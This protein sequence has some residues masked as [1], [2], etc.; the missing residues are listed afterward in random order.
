MTCPICSQLA[1]VESA[2]QKY[3]WEEGNTHLPSESLGLVLVKDLRPFSSRKL[4]LKQCPVCG[5]W[6]L[7]QTDYEYLVNGSEDEE[8]LYR[9]TEAQAA[10]YLSQG[11]GGGESST[12]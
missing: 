10:Q 1:D 8:H 11:E 7:Y 3:G 12:R 4:H 2:F 6:Y 5:G 9:L